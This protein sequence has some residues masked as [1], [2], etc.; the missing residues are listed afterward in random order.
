MKLMK[1]GKGYLTYTMA[2]LA[3]VGAI[4]GYFMGI[5]DEKTATVMIWGGLSVFGIRRA[6]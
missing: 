4:A 6:I 5:V 1:L 2:G 3:V